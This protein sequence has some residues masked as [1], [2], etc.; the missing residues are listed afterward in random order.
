M[1]TVR[2]STTSLFWFAVAIIQKPL[3]LPYIHIMIT[4]TKFLNSNPV[5]LEPGLACAVSAVSLIR[6]GYKM[7]PPFKGLVGGPSAGDPSNPEDLGP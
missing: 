5:F 3:Y 4:E 7:A 6:H 2:A 1:S